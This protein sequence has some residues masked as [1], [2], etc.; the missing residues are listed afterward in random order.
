MTTSTNRDLH[1]MHFVLLI[2]KVRQI[3]LDMAHMI[4]SND[5]SWL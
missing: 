2:A 5:F 1:S 3:P 4:A